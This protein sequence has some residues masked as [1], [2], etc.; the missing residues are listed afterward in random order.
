LVEDE[1]GNVEI[2][3][4]L[5][6]IQTVNLTRAFAA[7]SYVKV[8]DAE[9]AVTYYY[10]E[11]DGVNNVRSICQVAEAALADTKP[12]QSGEYRFATTDADGNTVYS[13]YSESAREILKGF[14]VE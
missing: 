7:I 11:F 9:G 4:A 12:A 1:N 14:I 5:T 13:R 10:S 6:N 8:V 3:A 2:R